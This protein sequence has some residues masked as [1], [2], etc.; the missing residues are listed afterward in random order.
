MEIF[1]SGQIIIKPR[2]WKSFTDPDQWFHQAIPKNSQKRT[3]MNAFKPVR[4]RL[5]SKSNGFLGFWISRVQQENVGAIIVG[6]DDYQIRI[7]WE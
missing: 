6:P 2:D 4:R 5:D 7:E 3:E 1:P